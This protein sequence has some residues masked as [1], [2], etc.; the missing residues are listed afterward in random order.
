MVYFKKGMFW[1]EALLV[2]MN[3]VLLDRSKGA[4][5]SSGLLR[6]VSPVEP[7]GPGTW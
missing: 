6:P 1:R 4:Q 5:E 3:V 2:G 7:A